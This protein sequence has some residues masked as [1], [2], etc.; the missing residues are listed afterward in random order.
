MAKEAAWTRTAEKVTAYI[1]KYVRLT[2]ADKRGEILEL[3]DKMHQIF[4]HWGIM[5]CPMMHPDILYASPNCPMVLGYSN[6]YIIRNSSIDK[7]FAHIHEADQEGLH[8]CFSYVH[9]HMETTPPEEHHAYRTVFHYRFR[10]EGGQ[11]IYLYDEKATLNLQ[12]SGNLY[13][14]LFRDVTPERAFPGVK[15]EVFRQEQSLVKV[16]EYRPSAGSEL[17]TKREQE[18]VTLIRQG[19][20][21][22]EIA[23]QLK[24]SNNTVRNIKSRLFAKYNV[25]SSIELLNMV[26]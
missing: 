23:W 24:I 19:L 18:L 11:Y 6:D 5:T 12:G 4:P 16:K 13:Y 15:V 3:F 25:N 21:G 17:L 20:S 14:V 8:A 9:Y 1:E 2:G 22:K 7:Y 10:K 26:G